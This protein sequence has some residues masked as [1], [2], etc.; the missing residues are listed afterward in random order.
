VG[1]LWRRVDLDMAAIH[2]VLSVLASDITPVTVSVS[3]TSINKY[4]TVSPSTS[5]SCV[6]TPS[7]GSGSYSYSWTKVTNN[8]PGLSI[9]TP[10]ASSTTVTATGMISGNTWVDTI[11]CT[12]TDASNPS[13]SGYIN[14]LVT[15]V[16]L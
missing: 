13:N 12:A 2:N 3:P 1:G 7:G 11:R 6:A 16:R 4:S 9:D 15:F 14:V 10:F 8:Y 5:S